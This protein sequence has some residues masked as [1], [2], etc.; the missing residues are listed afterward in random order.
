MT[1]RE[2]VEQTLETIRTHLL[3]HGGNVELVD[4]SED[5]TVQ[6]R[7]QGACKGCPMARQTMSMGIEQILKREVPEVKAVLGVD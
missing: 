3:S 1:L 5:G 7:L 6:L 2:Q 4:V